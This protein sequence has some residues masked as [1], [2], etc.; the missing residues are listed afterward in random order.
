MS[1]HRQADRQ[2]ILPQL[3]KFAQQQVELAANAQIA[4]GKL[5]LW[6]GVQLDDFGDGEDAQAKLDETLAAVAAA[7]QLLSVL[8]RPV[9]GFEPLTVK[10]A[11]L[12][13]AK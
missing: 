1:A 8:D 4:L 6:S 10:Q 13:V 2:A 9:I 5:E 12:R 11:L 7:K 3:A